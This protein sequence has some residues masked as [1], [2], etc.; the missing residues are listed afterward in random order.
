M[1]RS[2]L[3]VSCAPTPNLRRY[4]LTPSATIIQSSII[5]SD[6]LKWYPMLAE[7]GIDN[8]QVTVSFW[9]LSTRISK[10]DLIQRIFMV[11]QEDEKGS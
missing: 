3:I 9:N 10:Y 7:V 8:L 2:D 6:N 11:N 1:D 4:H 5:G